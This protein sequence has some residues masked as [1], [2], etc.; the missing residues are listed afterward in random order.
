MVAGVGDSTVD[1]PTRTGDVEEAGDDESTV[2]PNVQRYI[3]AG[4]ISQE[5]AEACGFMSNPENEVLLALFET[6]RQRGLKLELHRIDSQNGTYEFKVN[7]AKDRLHGAII[8]LAMTAA[9]AGIGL[10][11][12][13]GI[14]L[15]GRS[16]K[17]T[18]SSGIDNM[19]SL[20]GGAILQVFKSLGETAEAGMG[21]EAAEKQAFADMFDQ[22][23]QA[24]TSDVNHSNDSASGIV[25]G[26]R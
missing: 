6:A 25:S 13:F 4:V 12:G 10:G 20:T 24:I 1:D 21:V 16:G 9:G 8:S 2:H 3:D 18:E 19:G 26:M 22:N 7:A 11:A 14:G 23:Y 17:N 5:D 15:A